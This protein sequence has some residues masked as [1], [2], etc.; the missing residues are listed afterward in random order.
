MPNE[1]I[2]KMLNEQINMEFASAYIYLAMYNY[3]EQEGLHG[4]AHWYLVQSQEECKHAMK[5][6]RYL[7]AEG[8]R[9]ILLP[10]SQPQHEYKCIGEVLDSAL[11]HEQW[12]T[13]SI[14]RLV[15][16]AQDELDF[17][18]LQFLGW[19]VSEQAEEE[20]N[21]RTLCSNLHLFG[22]DEHSLFLLDKELAN[23][24]E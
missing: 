6:I 14:H 18:T 7:L 22:G 2:T 12:V 13:A 11:V 8:R 5:I 24:K 1:K 23:R 21:A 20:D 10:V 4:F 16:E 9:V 15:K 19:F 17:R 3:F